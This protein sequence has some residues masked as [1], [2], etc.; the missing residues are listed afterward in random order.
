MTPLQV[1]RVVGLVA[2]GD[3]TNKLARA[4]VDLVLDAPDPSA[5]DVDAL[6]A[7][8]D[9]RVVSDS[10]A[11]REAVAAAVAAQPGPAQKVRDGNEKAVGPLVGAV[12]R[13]H[14]RRGRRGGRA[15]DA[16]GA[17][18]RLTR[19][20]RARTRQADA[21][22]SGSRTTRSSSAAGVPRPSRLLVSTQSEPSGASTTARSRP[23]SS[24]S[25]AEGAVTPPLPSSGTSHSRC[26]RSAV[27]YSAPSAIAAP[28][29]AASS[30]AHVSSGVGE[31]RGA[32]PALHLRPAV[33][34]ARLQAVH[35]V[36]GV[37]AELRGVQAAGV[38]PG[39][40]LHVAVPEGEHRRARVRV[41][42]GHVAV[43]G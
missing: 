38:V 1:A 4:V 41:V 37:G 5:A 10:G 13:G 17:P 18:A 31:L 36:E 23:N 29:G 14:R 34:G 43:G 3:L 16:A 33:V 2:S 11:L 39:Q 42:A 32:A 28:D 12:M 30:G 7:E 21:G 26:P 8:H 9:L 19:G 40:A 20:G 24:V 22:T 35:L 25:S 27:T 15:P 6:V